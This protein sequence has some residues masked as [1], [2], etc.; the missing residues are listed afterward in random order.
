MSP[1]AGVAP[2][3]AGEASLDAA[4]RLA[5][6]K[7]DEER[8]LG[9]ALS[10]HHAGTLS[11]DVQARAQLLAAV[12]C[13]FLRRLLNS[14]LR[15]RRI[16]I[17]A[18]RAL[19]CDIDGARKMIECAVPLAHACVEACTSMRDSTESGETHPSSLAPD[20]ASA[21]SGVDASSE[22]EPRW[23]VAEFLECVEILLQFAS[24]SSPKDAANLGRA[25]EALFGL[26]VPGGA[27]ESARSDSDLMI[28]VLTLAREVAALDASVS[29]NA[30]SKLA[31]TLAVDS[32]SRSSPAW[33]L[34]CE[35]LAT[36]TLQGANAPECLDEAIGHALSAGDAGRPAAL[37]LAASSLRCHGLSFGL[38]K[39]VPHFSRLRP[40]L[41]VAAG[42]LRLYIEGHG[43][44]ENLCAACMM[45]EAAIIALGQES[46]EIEASGRLQDA[47]D[48][49]RNLHRAVGDIHEYCGDLPEEPIADEQLAL[50]AR[51]AAAWQLEDPRMFSHEFQVSLR[52]FCKLG[53]DEYRV[54]LP[55]IHEMHDWHLSPALRKVFECALASLRENVGETRKQCCLMLTEVA[56]DAA[57]YLPDAP[58]PNSPPMESAPPASENEALRAASAFAS[59]VLSVTQTKMPRPLQ[60]E[61]ASHHGVLKLCEWSR[62]FWHAGS[63][64]CA[65]DD[66]ALWELG[67]LCAALVVSVPEESIALTSA[68]AACAGAWN[69]VT[70]CLFAGPDVDAATWR[71]A[72]R[73]AGFS[74]D[75]HGG[76]RFALAREAARR[77]QRDGAEACVLRAPPGAVPR[78]A[79]E[80]EWAPADRAA[81]AA[82][83]AFLQLPPGAVDL[84]SFFT[85]AE[86][87]VSAAPFDEMD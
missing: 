33:T 40:L 85:E 18:M 6:G 20:V 13:D 56:L 4:L 28:R 58:L 43:S 66:A 38:K 78:N 86:A 69:A 16:A 48:C 84:E 72:M 70:R 27:M 17:A 41:V 5:A 75:R 53:C 45:L 52:S 7:K 47:A 62:A 44:S 8:V 59:S 25:A 36:Q 71:L 37:Q 49:L 15:L 73:V 29:Q 32:S 87:P 31:Q 2:Q 1:A 14:Q 23:G 42:E 19:A 11:T 10:M 60:A 46:E 35:L 50:L 22:E 68:A 81:T 55:S 79:E 26:L 12:D 74:L 67:V 82:V 83:Q 64:S 51:V 34:A 3:F 54:L 30:A 61:D 77:R 57:A 21:G 65:G 76:L 9:L 80:D 63:Q 39:G 24:I